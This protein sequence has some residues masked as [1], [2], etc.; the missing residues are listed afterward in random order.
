MQ[1]REVKLGLK[2]P[3]YHPPTEVSKIWGSWQLN[4]FWSVL[5]SKCQWPNVPNA[6]KNC[7]PIHISQAFPLK[8]Y[9][10]GGKGSKT[11]NITQVKF[12]HH[13]DWWDEEEHSVIDLGI[14][15]PIWFHVLALARE[16]F[17][18]LG[19]FFSFFFLSSILVSITY[20]IWV[21]QKKQIFLIIL[22]IGQVFFIHH[23]M[24]RTNLTQYQK[25]RD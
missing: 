3:L 4:A 6:K 11:I 10:I 2:K 1:A 12:H 24:V 7:L 14:L 15:I 16:I 8:Y 25:V 20:G 18:Q 19:A 22:A 9:R 21:G 13:G 5:L 17:I 23:F